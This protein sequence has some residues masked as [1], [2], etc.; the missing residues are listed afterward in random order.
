MEHKI[1]SLLG[2]RNLFFKKVSP[3]TRSYVTEPARSLETD[4]QLIIHA[5]PS[6]PKN[7]RNGTNNH[8]MT[9]TS[10]AATRAVLLDGSG[11]YG[12][13][14][15]QSC[16]STAPLTKNCGNLTMDD[17][18]IIT[19]KICDCVITDSHSDG[20]AKCNKLGTVM[21]SCIKINQFFQLPCEWIF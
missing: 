13:Y 7:C 11:G 8:M 9:V 16:G 18:I 4:D 2:N 3:A 5:A 21:S 14:R 20:R 15:D 6:E 17:S 12:H 1:H 19:G 10:K